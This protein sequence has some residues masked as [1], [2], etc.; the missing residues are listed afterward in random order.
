MKD[1]YLATALRVFANVSL[2]IAAPVIIGVI[3]GKYLD[4]QYNTEPWLF[5]ATVGLCFLISIYG[6]VVNAKKEFKKIEDDAQ[7]DKLK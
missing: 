6:L 4:K 3:L 2:W 1:N 5:L 7:K